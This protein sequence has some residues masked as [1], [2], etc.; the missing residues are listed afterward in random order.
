MHWL[1]TVGTAAAFAAVY[2][3]GREDIRNWPLWIVSILIY[4]YIFFQSHL[5]AD[6]ALQVF[7]LGMSFYGWW[8]WA[9]GEEDGDTLPVSRCSALCTIS[10]ILI[11]IAGTWLV[12]KALTYTPSDVPYWDA[13][14]TVSALVA[15]FLMARKKIDHW[16]WWIVIDLTAAGVYVYKGLHITAFQYSVFAG[17]AVWGW[18]QWRRSLMQQGA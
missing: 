3:T 6:A 15:T 17:M 10:G 12:G 9:H 7:Y 13:F 1:E 16:V 14:T 5:Y 11:T 18:F 8:Q 2:L 4:I